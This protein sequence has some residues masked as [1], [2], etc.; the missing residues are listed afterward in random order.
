[1]AGKT[2]FVSSRSWWPRTPNMVASDGPLMSASTTPTRQPCIAKNMARFVVMVLLP[3]PFAAHHG[4]S[5]LDP[6]HTGFEPGDL[7]SHLPSDV[8]ATIA[9]N[10]SITFRH[11]LPKTPKGARWTMPLGNSCYCEKTHTPSRGKERKL[12][13][14]PGG[15]GQEEGQLPRVPRQPH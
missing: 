13:P 15:Y 12:H 14:T 7:L 6:G 2:P 1:M 10:V 9:G 8:G 5:T 4:K 11:I 3:T